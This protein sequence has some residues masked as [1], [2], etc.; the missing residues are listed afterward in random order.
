MLHLVPLRNVNDLLSKEY[1]INYKLLSIQ[2]IL[3]SIKY[4]GCNSTPGFCVQLLLKQ[5]LNYRHLHL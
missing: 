5:Y 2:F 4:K 1:Y 3:I